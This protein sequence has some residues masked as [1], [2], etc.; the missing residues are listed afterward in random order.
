MTAERDGGAAISYMQRGNL[1]IAYSDDYEYRGLLVT[2]RTKEETETRV[3]AAVR[4]IA[5][6]MLRARDEVKS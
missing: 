5:S 6:A 2:G 4:E 1:W 3:P